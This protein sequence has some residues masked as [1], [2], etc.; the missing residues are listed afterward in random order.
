MK[1]FLSIISAYTIGQ[2]EYGRGDKNPKQVADGVRLARLA[3]CMQNLTTAHFP[4]EGSLSVERERE[5]LMTPYNLCQEAKR[6]E[7]VM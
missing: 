1:V 4:W 7:I 5:T 2:F 6:A 3:A